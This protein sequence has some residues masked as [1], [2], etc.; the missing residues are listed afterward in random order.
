ME[1][2]SRAEAHQFYGAGPSSHLNGFGKKGLEWD[3]NDWRWDGD[4]FLATPLNGNVMASECRN[5][6]LSNSSSSCSEETD[7]GI[8]RK[9]KGVSEKRRKIVVVEDE[10]QH[11]NGAGMLTLNLGM[12]AYPVAEVADLANWEGKNEKRSKLQ[13][14]NSSRSPCC[15]VEGCGADLSESKDYHRRHKVCEMHAKASSA[16]VNNVLQRFC[17]QCSRLVF[18]QLFCFFCMLF[19]LLLACNH[20][21]WHT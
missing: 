20:I 10:E 15:Q 21:T 19:V 7:L 2:R 18:I 14:G 8:I 1:A 13:G 6:Q 4:L 12:N 11:G 5:K 9:G 3:L 17:Q 16:V